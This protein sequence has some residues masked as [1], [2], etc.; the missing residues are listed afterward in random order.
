MSAGGASAEKAILF[1]FLANL[2]IAIAKSVA[3]F[4]TGSSSML[5]EA[6]HSL[7][8]TANQVLLHLGLRRSR[9]PPDAE[10]PLGYGK[11][12][13]FWSFIVALLLF[14]VGGLFSLWEGYHKLGAGGRLEAPWVGVGVL[15]VA[16]VLEGGSL[17]G[18][19]REIR[20]LRGELGLRA[21]LRESRAAELVVV[22]GEDIGA[23]LGL[24]IALAC[25][26]AAMWTGDVRF[27][28]AGS[29]AIGGV[30]I[31]IALFIAVHI[32]SL[33]I[34]RSAH[35]AVQRSIHRLIG[36]DPGVRRIF[37]V[38]TIQVGPQVMVAAKVALDP[39]LGIE[40]AC[41][42]LNVIEAG[43]KAE[44]PEV[45]WVFLEPDVTD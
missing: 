14:S 1:A 18:C 34:G 32:K 15:A 38:I 42:R 9:R 37:N 33:L 28:A 26:G 25:L 31:V 3:A 10:H 45:G 22:L 2:G 24:L 11:V 29:M 16:L 6:I 23:L 12:S 44:L 39:A 36:A 27:D 35:P 8:D 4:V 40:A 43:L 7:A 19:L 41:E 17:W 13:Y 20:K 5:A 21:W 30:L